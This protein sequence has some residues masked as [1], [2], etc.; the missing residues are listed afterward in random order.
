MQHEY[1]AHH[2]LISTWVRLDLDGFRPELRITRKASSTLRLSSSH[3]VI[4]RTLKLNQTFPTREAAENYGLE[5][6]KR[7]VDE[8]RLAVTYA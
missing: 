5:V 8:H 3:P 4:L 1:N 7:W 2:I 6:G